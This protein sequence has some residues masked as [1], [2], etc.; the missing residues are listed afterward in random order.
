M[1]KAV[2]KEKVNE[3][4]QLL[5]SCLIFGQD[6][7]LKANLKLPIKK[8]FMIYWAKN[9]NIEQKRLKSVSANS[10]YNLNFYTANLS[11]IH[12]LQAFRFFISG[13]SC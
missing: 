6:L 10:Y 8:K 3:A 4:G 12:F 13:W 1:K 9:S 11:L 2:F 5:S 7:R